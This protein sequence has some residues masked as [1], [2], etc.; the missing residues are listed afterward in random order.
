MKTQIRIPTVQYGY[1]EFPFEGTPEEAIAEHNRT[2]KLYSGGGGLSDKEFNIWLDKY[3]MSQEGD[4]EQ[5]MKMNPAQMEVIQ[6][7]KR[8]FKRIAYKHESQNS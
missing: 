4:G 3:L 7:L 6:T 2:L 5:Y 8:A 1:L